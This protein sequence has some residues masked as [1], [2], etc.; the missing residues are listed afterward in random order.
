MSSLQKQ[1]PTTQCAN[2]YR[3]INFALK[4]TNLTFLNP[5]FVLKNRFR[6]NLFLFCEVY[7]KL[8]FLLAN[9]WRMRI[10]LSPHL[11]NEILS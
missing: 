8:C 11:A 5:K 3:E 2:Q 1:T 9:V 4:I 10:D 6:K 7:S